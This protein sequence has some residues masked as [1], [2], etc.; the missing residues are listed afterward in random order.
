MR[1][2]SLTTVLRCA[3]VA[4][5]VTTPAVLGAPSAG[6]AEARTAAASA[7]K[8]D[9]NKDG[10][11]DLA[12]SAPT[13]TVGGKA[14]AGYVA[15]VYGSASGADTAHRQVISQATEGVPGDPADSAYFGAHTVARDLDGDGY[16]DL[17][18]QTGRS[19]AVTVLWGSANGLADATQLPRATA[20]TG[21][22]AS[23]RAA[24]STATATPTWPMWSPPAR[25]RTTRRPEYASGSVRSP[26]TARTRAA[27][28]PTP[29]GS[30][31][32]P[33]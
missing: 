16:T 17:A 18:V 28:S 5:L 31:R 29:A 9:F 23:S 24:T 32:R 8:V 3:T 12:V 13:G 4:A 25:A 15:V 1:P 20:T 22:T 30:T 27:P 7:P 2:G 14:K 33:L 19:P 6:A 26:V 10:R 21:A 11:A